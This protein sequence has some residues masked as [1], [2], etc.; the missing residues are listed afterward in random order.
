MFQKLHVLVLLS[1]LM[2]FIS[3]R[4][5]SHKTGDGQNFSLEKY[6]QTLQSRFS[7][8]DASFIIKDSS[9]ENFDTLKY[10]YSARDYKPLFIKDFED[11]LFMDS[12]LSIFSKA[13]EHGLQPDLFNYNI[14]KEEYAKSLA[15]GEAGYKHLANTEIL[16]SDA[17]IKYSSGLRYGVVNPYKVFADSYFLPVTDSSKRETLKPLYTENVFEYLKESAPQ[18]PQYK[19]LQSA[20]FHFSGLN[21]L[22][23]E[24]IPVTEKKYKPGD[25]SPI[26]NKIIKKLEVLGY[27]NQGTYTSDR[28]DSALV[29][30]V[31]LFQKCNG[32]I[33]DGTIGKSTIEKLN[34]TPDEYIEKIKL[35]MERLRWST[36]PDSSRYILVNIPDFYLHLIENGQ[37]KFNI[38]ICLGRKKPANFEER[39]KVYLKT[40]NWRNRPDDWETPQI[41]GQVTHMVLNPTWT[42]PTS[43]IKEEIYREVIKDSTYLMKKNFK[44]FKNGKE[45]NVDKV[46]LRNYSPNKIPYSFV[47][48]PGAGNALG[49]IKFMFKNKFGIYLHDTPTRGPFSNSVR[50]VSHGCM[51]VE[52]P[53]LLAE[54]LLKGN[55]KWNIDY[56]KI[57]TG[58]AGPD[59][60]K[61]AEFK[62]KRNELRRGSSYG[63]TTEVKLE[64]NIPV[65]VDYYTAWVDDNGIVNFRPDIYGKDKILSKHLFIQD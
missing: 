57:E 43:I 46:N 36:Y 5:E 28:F 52:K 37:E 30:P 39:I 45:V 26:F 49:K 54:Y 47:Q 55:S 11:T 20:L 40:H 13:E 65:F 24:K 23:W 34:T 63:K 51:R 41:W 64:Q 4:Q 12:V 32:L 10:F 7:K 50:A 6:Q 56:I 25:K 60:T 16:I 48:D 3:C 62:L 38:K 22:E 1:V 44:V 59:N 33:D 15:G 17:I 21:K 61:V 2:F 53:F 42:V 29:K 18:S 14:I 58:F 19:K 8:G 35:S 31:K 27:L 9:I